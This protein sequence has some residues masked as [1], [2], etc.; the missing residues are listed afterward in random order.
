MYCLVP[1]NFNIH[2]MMLALVLLLLFP[3]RFSFLFPSSVPQNG[4]TEAN[5][6]TADV[7]ISRRGGEGAR[8]H[9]LSFHPLLICRLWIHRVPKLLRLLA[10]FVERVRTASA[11]GTSSLSWGQVSQASI[12]SPSSVVLGKVAQAAGTAWLY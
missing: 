5:L 4:L 11:G 3:R 6:C 1:Y 2:C 7:L 10:S 12:I 9:L 8:S